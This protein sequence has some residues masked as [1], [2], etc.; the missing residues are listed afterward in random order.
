MNPNRT[1]YES[2]EQKQTIASATPGIFGSSSNWSQLEWDLA[3]AFGN[4]RV[5]K[6]DEYQ[7]DDG[8][9]IYRVVIATYAVD[10][11]SQQQ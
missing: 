1:I 9:R 6:F 3:V 7:P 10:Y 4:P 11:G 2:L 8:P 5:I